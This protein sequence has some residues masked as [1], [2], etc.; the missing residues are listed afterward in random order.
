MCAYFHK[1]CFNVAVTGL[2][3][4][5]CLTATTGHKGGLVVVTD[6]FHSCSVF[7]SPRVCLGREG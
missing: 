4:V 7:F 1:V 2:G 3:R 5:G 6:R